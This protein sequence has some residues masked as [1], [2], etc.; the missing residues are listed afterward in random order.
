[1][2]TNARLHQPSPTE[3]LW[4]SQVTAH[5]GASAHAPENTLAAVRRALGLGADA[6]ECDVHRTRDGEL[7]V[8]HDPHLRRTTD[9]A[10]RFPGRDRWRVRDL[11]LAEIKSLDAGSWF[12]RDYAAERVPTLREWAVEVGDRARMLVEIKQPARYPGIAGDLAGL[13]HQVPELAAAVAGRRLVI[14]SFDHAWLQGFRELVPAVPVGL[15]YESRPTGPEIAVAS[16][17]AHQ[18]NPSLNAVDREM[19]R[20]VQASGM[21]VHVWTPNSHRQ[22]RSALRCGVDGLITNRPDRVRPAKGRAN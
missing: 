3:P 1:V 21:E 19:V 9:A 14:Q 11:T 15:L 17:Y 20:A 22:L 6:V 12:G 18:V 13:L 16:R 2:D 8:I 4:P 7:V 10:Q 5:R